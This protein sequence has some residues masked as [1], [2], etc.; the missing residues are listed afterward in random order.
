MHAYILYYYIHA[1]DS[2]Y[3]CFCKKHSYFQIPPVGACCAPEHTYTSSACIHTFGSVC[4]QRACFN[5]ARVFQQGACK[6]DV[7]HSIIHTLLSTHDIQPS[8][9]QL[10]K[11]VTVCFPANPHTYMHNHVHTHTYTY[12]YIYI[13]IHIYTHTYTHT[14][15]HTYTHTYIHTYIHTYTTVAGVK[16]W[17]ERRKHR[18]C[19]SMFTLA[20]SN[21][22]ACM[23]VCL[24]T[25]SV[26]ACPFAPVYFCICSPSPPIKLVTVVTKASR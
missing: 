5:R 23:F 22:C 26:F 19:N 12:T 16:V 1:R 10:E 14:H 6:C 4:L 17:V 18:F 11:Y 24:L 9:S 15:I 7:P 2:R 3:A 25:V 8:K 20:T 21:V 13:Y